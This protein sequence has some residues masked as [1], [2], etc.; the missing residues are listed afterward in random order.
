[1]L[2]LVT[3][4]GRGQ[5]QLVKHPKDQGRLWDDLQGPRDFINVTLAI[6]KYETISTH[7]V[8][9]I[10]TMEDGSGP[11]PYGPT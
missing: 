11:E 5:H 10:Y 6:K 3:V 4:E 7:T 9:L 8:D 2:A 1:M